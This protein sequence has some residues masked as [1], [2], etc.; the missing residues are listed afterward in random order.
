MCECWFVCLYVC[1][2]VCMYMCMYVCMYEYMYVCLYVCMYA[3]ACMRF[4]VNSQISG[5]WAVEVT[6]ASDVSE[7]IRSVRSDAIVLEPNTHT[8][9]S[10]TLHQLPVRSH[11]RAQTS[12]PPAGA[13]LLCNF[14]HNVCVCSCVSWMRVCMY[15]CMYACM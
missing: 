15:A 4:T 8:V 3:F 1:M 10:F 6:S 14:V 12:A 2:Y 7:L 5:L 11:S 13:S 9:F